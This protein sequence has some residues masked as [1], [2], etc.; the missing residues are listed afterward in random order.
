M[1]SRCQHK[2][3][4]AVKGG[5]RS[6]SISSAPFKT[7]RNGFPEFCVIKDQQTGEQLWLT[8]SLFQIDPRSEVK[9]TTQINGG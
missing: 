6:F 8:E 1:P 5:K 9:I 4:E 7:G 2:Q 3:G